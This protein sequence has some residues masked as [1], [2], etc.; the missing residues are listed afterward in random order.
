[1]SGGFRSILEFLD[2]SGHLV[3]MGIVIL[4]VLGALGVFGLEL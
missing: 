4:W 3:V 2:Y 1:M